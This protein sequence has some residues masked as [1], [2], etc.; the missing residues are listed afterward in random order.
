V[1]SKEIKINFH[2]CSNEVINFLDKFER[3]TYVSTLLV[4]NNLICAHQSNGYADWDNKF[5]YEGKYKD[6]LLIK[7]GIELTKIRK[8]DVSTVIWDE[9]LKIDKD[10]II[11]KQRR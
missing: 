9:A 6:S 2:R 4:E 7:I 1:D 8:G 5:Y 10:N 11:D 3:T